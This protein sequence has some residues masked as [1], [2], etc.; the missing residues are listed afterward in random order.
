MSATLTVSKGGPSRPVAG[1]VHDDEVDVLQGTDPGRLF[2]GGARLIGEAGPEAR[3]GATA[4]D[5]LAGVRP[6]SWSSART[7]RRQAVGGRA[8]EAR[9][10]TRGSRSVPRVW[11]SRGGRGLSRVAGPARV[12]AMT[13]RQRSPPFTADPCSIRADGPSAPVCPSRRVVSLACVS[14]PTIPPQPP[15][16]RQPGNLASATRVRAPPPAFGRRPN[17]QPEADPR[18]HRG[19]PP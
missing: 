9:P 5:A 18:S 16:G 19:P 14:R 1:S 2:P 12:P 8:L 15:S 3:R 4:V 6:W 10:R 7:R 11:G 17:H 13:G